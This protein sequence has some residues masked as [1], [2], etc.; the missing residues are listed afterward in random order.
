LGHAKS[1]VPSVLWQSFLLSKALK[2]QQEGE[3]RKTEFIIPGLEKKVE[4]LESLLKEK[5]AR[6]E[7]TE[8]NLA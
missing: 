8:A 4:D 2:L 7:S 3:D 6:I 5:D 1:Y